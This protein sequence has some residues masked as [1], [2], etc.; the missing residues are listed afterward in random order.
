MREN[1]EKLYK[2]RKSKNSLK[3]WQLGYKNE[4]IESSRD[5]AQFLIVT[6]YWFKPQKDIVHG[7]TDLYSLYLSRIYQTDLGIL[8]EL[9]D[10]L[11]EKTRYMN[12]FHSGSYHYSIQSLQNLEFEGRAQGTPDR[13]KTTLHW[14]E[15]QEFQKFY[16]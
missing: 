16:F 14:A 11:G 9:E 15:F 12:L 13:F 2:G 7:F 3:K 5:S 8:F 4:I 10:F 1:H 6:P